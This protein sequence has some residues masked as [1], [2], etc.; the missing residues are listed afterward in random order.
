[1][2]SFRFK[3][4]NEIQMKTSLSYKQRIE[5]IISYYIIIEYLK[6]LNYNNKIFITKKV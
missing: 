4:D 3:F 5:Q 2:I 1:M 6:R